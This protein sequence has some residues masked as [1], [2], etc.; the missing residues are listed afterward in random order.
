[1]AKRKQRL[2]ERL[3]QEFGKLRDELRDRSYPVEQEYRKWLDYSE[4]HGCSLAARNAFYAGFD[5]AL[6]IINEKEATNGKA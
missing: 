4:R 3:V 2:G 6:R 1:M 5:A